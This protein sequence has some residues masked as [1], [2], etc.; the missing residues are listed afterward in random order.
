MEGETFQNPR[1][2]VY[3]ENAIRSDIENTTK[4]FQN[5]TLFH[6]YK[7]LYFVTFLLAT[8]LQS[9]HPNHPLNIPPHSKTKPF[10]TTLSIRIVLSSY[11]TR[12]IPTECT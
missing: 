11:R 12:L 10:P 3:E 5:F 7:Q 2:T 4:S 6:G 1:D 9:H 8:S